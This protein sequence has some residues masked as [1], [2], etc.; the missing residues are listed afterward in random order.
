MNC[1]R[2]SA[3]G[4]DQWLPF[5][6]HC[7]RQDQIRPQIYQERAIDVVGDVPA[8]PF[9]DHDLVNP[10][11]LSTV[12]QVEFA[13]GLRPVEVQWQANPADCAV[14]AELGKTAGT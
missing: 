11:A 12:R 13:A 6:P 8:R 5:A 1:R 9:S 2:V 3:G 7:G 10:A 14:D 4:V